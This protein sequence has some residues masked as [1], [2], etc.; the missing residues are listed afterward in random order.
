[1][2][3]PPVLYLGGRATIHRPPTGPP[4]TARTGEGQRAERGA[5]RAREVDA[6]GPGG[7]DRQGK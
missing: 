2:L 1:M 4:G 7:G 5:A 3:V 6:F